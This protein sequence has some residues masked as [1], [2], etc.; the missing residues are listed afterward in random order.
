MNSSSQ[1]I[2]VANQTISNQ[3]SLTAIPKRI[4]YASREIWE[5]QNRLTHRAH[6]TIDATLNHPRFRAAYDFLLLREAAGES[7]GESGEWWT[8][9]Q[10]GD[11][12]QRDELLEQLPNT[13]RKRRRKRRSSASNNSD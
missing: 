4:S 3:L 6:R 1:F 13:R 9:Y 5:L 10:F 7:L 11:T 8:V 12:T 2:D